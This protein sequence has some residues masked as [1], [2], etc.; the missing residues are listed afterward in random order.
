MRRSLQNVSPAFVSW[1]YTKHVCEHCRKKIL[2]SSGKL[3]VQLDNPKPKQ[4]FVTIHT[5]CFVS[6]A[7]KRATWIRV[8]KSLPAV[9]RP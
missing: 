9:Q 6:F 2:A 8:E 1:W 7:L 5:Q 4:S 3:E